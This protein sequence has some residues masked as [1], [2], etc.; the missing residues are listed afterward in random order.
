MEESRE[1]YTLQ[2]IFEKCF[3]CVLTSPL[4]ES[5]QM[6]GM[7]FDE[8]QGRN[9]MGEALGRLRRKVST[10]KN[11]GFVV[12]GRGHGVMGLLVGIL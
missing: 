12:E 1:L 4:A 10:L 5:K 3:G 7:R 6:D 8:S 11:F 2:N 9:R